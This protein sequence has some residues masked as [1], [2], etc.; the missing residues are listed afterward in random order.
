MTNRQFISNTFGITEQYLSMLLNGE[1][2]VS[3]PIAEKLSDIF[4]GK[5]ISQWKRATPKELRQ[6]F[7]QLDEVEVI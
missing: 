4:P 3:W 5:S 7:E 2:K 6:A 1:R